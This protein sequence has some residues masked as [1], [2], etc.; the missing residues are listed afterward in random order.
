M[1][2]GFSLIYNEIFSFNHFAFFGLFECIASSPVVTLII[3]QD[4][5]TSERN[6]TALSLVAKNTHTGWNVS[7]ST[8]V[9][10]QLRY[11]TNTLTP[12]VDIGASKSDQNDYQ[13]TNAYP[14]NLNISSADNQTLSSE[15]GIKFQKALVINDTLVKPLVSFSIMSD[16]PL[17]KQGGA[18]LSF[19][20]SSNTFAVPAVNQTKTYAAA[21]VGVASVLSD[22]ITISSLVTGKARH[23]EHTVKAVIKLTYAF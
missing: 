12:F 23:H 15:I 14:F 8:E 13:E 21:S 16:Q 18:I 1:Q 5:Y 9:G 22:S 19:T 4:R 20:D 7:G 17:R 2:F 6:I 11:G 10:Y 3:G